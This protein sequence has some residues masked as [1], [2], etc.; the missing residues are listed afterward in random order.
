[1]RC[2]PKVSWAESYT[3]Q[4]LKEYYR[5]LNYALNMKDRVLLI[6]VGSRSNKEMYKAVRFTNQLTEFW[7]CLYTRAFFQPVRTTPFYL[8]PHANLQDSLIFFFLIFGPMHC[9]WVFAF[10]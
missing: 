1:M 5:I 6:F 9:G 10:I 2:D 8:G 4:F 7:P 3:S